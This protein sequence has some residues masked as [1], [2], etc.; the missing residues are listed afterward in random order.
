MSIVQR[1]VSSSE[2]DLPTSLSAV[3]EKIDAVSQGPQLSH[4]LWSCCTAWVSP[5]KRLYYKTGNCLCKV[6]HFMPVLQNKS[7]SASTLLFLLMWSLTI[8]KL[9]LST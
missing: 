7:I 1:E 8:L 6:A 3:K 5:R 2:T 4:P 9:C